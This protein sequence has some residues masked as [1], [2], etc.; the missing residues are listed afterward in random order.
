MSFETPP[1]YD[2]VIEVSRLG[3]TVYAE[4]VVRDGRTGRETEKKN[5]E[6]ALRDEG[7]ARLPRLIADK[8]LAELHPTLETTRTLSLD[9]GA[10]SPAL[11]GR[12]TIK[13]HG[14]LEQLS[15][16]RDI[17]PNALAEKL[18]VVR[19]FVG[20]STTPSP[21]LALPYIVESGGVW[22]SADGSKYSRDLKDTLIADIGEFA[23]WR[24]RVVGTRPKGHAA[25][26]HLVLEDTDDLERR[27]EQI[28]TRTLTSPTRMIIIHD[29]AATPRDGHVVMLARRLLT[30]TH[31]RPGCAALLYT[32]G[33]ADDL[34]AAKVLFGGF[35]RALDMSFPID[36]AVRVGLNALASA[37]ATRRVDWL[38]FLHPDAERSL[39]LLSALREYT[40]V[41][42]TAKS[43]DLIDLLGDSPSDDRSERSRVENV[44]KVA[45]AFDKRWSEDP[46]KSVRE[47][48]EAYTELYHRVRSIAP[49]L[50]EGWGAPGV[51][52]TVSG[53]DEV[54]DRR[55]ALVWTS[56]EKAPAKAPKPRPL[57]KGR[58]AWLQF[59]FDDPARNQDATASRDAN[60]ALTEMSRIT[61]EVPLSV[62]LFAEE[63]DAEIKQPVHEIKFYSSGPSDLVQ[64]AVTALADD[65]LRIRIC[66][67]FRHNMLQSIVVRHKVVP[68]P[69]P[70]EGLPEPDSASCVLETDYIVPYDLNEIRAMMTPTVNIFS[71]E[72]KS[73]THWIGVFSETAPQGDATDP[74]TTDLSG[75]PGADGMSVSGVDA[76]D[77]GA[78]P[79]APSDPGDPSS[80]GQLGFHALLTF[81]YGKI[82]NASGGL[83]KLLRDVHGVQ[84]NFSKRVPL[85]E[86]VR[87]WRASWIVELARRG[88][89]LYRELFIERAGA[90]QPWVK[91]FTAALARP[92]TISIARVSESS[93][94]LPWATLYDYPIYRGNEG[95]RPTLCGVFAEPP[96][97]PAVADDPAGSAR[98]RARRALLE[99]FAAC[100]GR[101]DCPQKDPAIASQTVCPF[102]FWGV[103]HKIEQPLQIAAPS[104]DGEHVTLP[105]LKN[106]KHEAGEPVEVLMASYPFQYISNHEQ[107]IEAVG[108]GSNATD[109]ASVVNVTQKRKRGE[110]I[111]TLENSTHH[112][113]YFF[114]HCESASEGVFLTVGA[115]DPDENG[116]TKSRIYSSDLNVL[117]WEPFARNPLVFINA[118]DSLEANSKTVGSFMQSFRLLNAAGV[119]GTEIKVSTLLASEF[120][121]NVLERLVR[122]E[123]LGEAILRTRLDLFAQ[124]NP[125]GFVYTSYAPAQYRLTAKPATGAWTY[126]PFKHDSPIHA[127]MGQAPS[128]AATPPAWPAGAALHHGRELFVVLENGLRVAVGEAFSAEHLRR[129]ID[130]IRDL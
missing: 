51:E 83:Q 95:E 5:E 110:I 109:T 23:E 61:D 126:D 4:R 101:D 20:G 42:H 28:V 69:A 14:E 114:C 118:C 9:P 58:E 68:P 89:A 43:R 53:F 100:S 63:G 102:G 54:E 107:V 59:R 99:S 87:A 74:Q 104:G 116:K 41:I 56:A 94:S 85:D 47:A 80:E 86:H 7:L 62:V 57:V 78:T 70:G 39:N 92:G 2:V 105:V 46:P 49:G 30:G 103:R 18:P 21:P 111:Q 33:L 3:D 38:L 67:Y 24:E 130:T 50:V 27:R 29:L 120:G 93:L 35:H 123:P 10:P 25:V 88:S 45:D 125:L 71:N 81:A 121:H 119:I 48:L 22:L 40:D 11:L 77:T 31:S 34:E 15:W 1:V 6:F 76:D 73:G 129:V 12:V 84:Y 55:R 91:D 16:E 128:D 66:V 108:D 19:G 32:R 96:E 117:E 13:I 90:E 106:A 36:Q 82:E 97:D 44:R 98:Y 115:D 113:L 127:I 75:Q 72:A 65:E 122:G 17:L 60:N 37:G 64:T 52:E 124:L 26:Y 8:L 112:L 79:G